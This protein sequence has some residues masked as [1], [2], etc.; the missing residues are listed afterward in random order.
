MTARVLVVDD[1]QSNLKLLQTRL[2]IEYFEVLT[3]TNGPDA[4]AI[5]EQ[6]GCDV[7]L[8]D[9]KMPGMD[10]FEVC[11]R[12]R[13]APETAHLPIVLLTAL[14]RPADRVRGLGS[15][16]DDFLTKPVDEIALIARV[17]SLA[18]LK[19]S[20]DELRGRATRG[21]EAEMIGPALDLGSSTHGRILVVDD[22][23]SSSQ[24]IVG[25]LTTHHDVI[26]TNEPGD[27]LAMAREEKVDLM[28]VSLGF[29]AFDGLRLCSR[30]RSREGTRNLPILLVA[31]PEDRPKVLRGLELGVND[32]LTRPIDRNELLARA[33]TNIRQ[34][35]YADRLRQSVQQSIEMALYDALTGLNNRRSFERSLPAMIETARQRGAALTMMILDIDHFKRVNDTH[36]HDVGDLVLKGFAAQLQEIVRGGDLLCRL[37]GEEFVIVT[38]G[39]DAIQAAWIAERARRATE[40]KEFVLDGEAGSVSITVSIGLAQWREEWDSAELYRRADRALYLSKSAGRNRVSADA[41]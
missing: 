17:R 7:V 11:R 25:A 38:P 24:R 30:V 36:G 8:L 14:D 23:R 39:C 12:L 37:G 19:F 41:A 9:V 26:L 13:T 20:I 15:G 28:I 22:H 3:A 29:G 6:G 31:D 33:R 18:R 1:V 2:S 16:A 35:R 10:G 32:Y 21:A 40:T 27:A 5:C 34:K 4:I